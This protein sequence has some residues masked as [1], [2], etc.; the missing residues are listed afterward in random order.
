[1]AT[2]LPPLGSSECLRGLTT[3]ML[4]TTLSYPPKYCPRVLRA[5]AIAAVTTSSAVVA[6]AVAD[7]AATASLFFE[8]A[9]ITRAV[10]AFAIKPLSYAHVHF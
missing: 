5:G 4:S 3:R 1:M 7:V 10:V 6:A 8:A 9:F 2:D